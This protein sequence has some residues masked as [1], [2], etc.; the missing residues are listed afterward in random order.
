LF[1][2]R[3]S[4]SLVKHEPSHVAAAAAAAAAAATGGGN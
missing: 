1:V 3:V 2:R 4:L